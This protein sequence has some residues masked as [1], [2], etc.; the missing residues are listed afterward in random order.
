MPNPRLHLVATGGTIAGAGTRPQASMEYRA[1]VLDA[2]A[3]HAS[4]PG[5]DEVAEFTLEQFASIDSKDA[6]PAFWQAL[7]ARLQEVLDDP[8]VDGVI[9][10]HGTDTLEET[11]YYLH[12]VLQT[13]KPVVLVGA[14]RP[15]TSLSA[16]G[17]MNLLDA[18][19]VAAC[20]GASGRG[21][22]VVMN[23]RIFGARGVAK[24]NASR[25]DA[26]ASPDAGPLGL[27]QDGRIVW[28][29]RPERLHTSA[30]RFTAGTP[31]LPVEILAGY[32]GISADLIRA[33]GA[34]GAQGL[35]WA[36]PGS[37]SAGATA[38]AALAE[39]QAAGVVVVCTTRTGSGCAPAVHGMVGGGTLSPWKARVLAML[40]LGSGCREPA[41]LQSLFDT[42]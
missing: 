13:T 15:A 16:D 20:L 7:A 9:V 29:A 37:G 31:L 5:L 22:M 23:H 4:V 36:G 17:P 27:V 21:V 30:T 24:I 14:M 33:A 32:A 12:L 19:A 40:A 25:P 10:T 8:A 3:L 28:L 11:A 35:V 42:H 34:C 38:L 26:F 2:A 18:A 1:G 41:A 6:T 39:L